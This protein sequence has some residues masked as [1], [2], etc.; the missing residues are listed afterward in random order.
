MLHVAIPIRPRCTLRHA[1]RILLP[2]AHV[3][4]RLQALTIYTNVLKTRAHD[5]TVSAVASNNVIS[6]KGADGFSGCATTFVAPRQRPRSSQHSVLSP[7]RRREA[8]FASPVVP[9][10]ASATFLTLSRSPRR[11][12][13][14]R[15]STCVRAA[16][17]VA[18]CTSRLTRGT[19]PIDI[20]RWEGVY[21]VQAVIVGHPT[22][23]ESAV[24]VASWDEDRDS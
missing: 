24:A 7:R 15:P 23:T 2:R 22:R 20:V 18:W 10:Q 17:G 9:M 1:P 11:R 6:L 13:P 16:C 8:T 5:P 4:R 19:S 12:L 3:A 21:A 14:R